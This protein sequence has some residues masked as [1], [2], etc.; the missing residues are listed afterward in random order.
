MP[1]GRMVGPAQSVATIKSISTWTAAQCLRLV[2]FAATGGKMLGVY[3]PSAAHAW[4]NAK[5]RYTRGTPPAGAF[6]FW[7]SPNHSYGHIGLSLGGGQVRH[8]G[9]G[10]P[11]R[12]GTSTIA[13]VVNRW[14]YTYLGWS[15]DL[16]GQVNVDVTPPPVTR[17]YPGHVHKLGSHDSHV[18]LIQRALKRELGVNLA[19]DNSYG[20]KTRAAVVAFQTKKRLVK[21]GIVGPVTWAALKP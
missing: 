8:L 16:Y 7:K 2:A 3:A 19:V 14:G 6:I 15:R 9:W 20:P 17:A 21:D 1:S 18:G 10:G 11:T 13:D 5:Y 12:V 4:A